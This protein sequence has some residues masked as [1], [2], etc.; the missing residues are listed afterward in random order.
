MYKGRTLNPLGIRKVDYQAERREAWENHH[1]VVEQTFELFFG[2]RE[3]GNIKRPELELFA[4]SLLDMGWEEG[5]R[6]GV[7][8]TKSR[9]AEALE[10]GTLVKP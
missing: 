1:K 4:K 2:G 3:M 9:I 10:N 7:K 8:S 5:V 6:Q